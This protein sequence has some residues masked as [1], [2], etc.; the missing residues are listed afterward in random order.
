MKLRTFVVAVMLL[1]GI[2]LQGQG[3]FRGWTMVPL[4][5]LPGATFS[6]AFG[7]NDRGDA[8][9][10]SGTTSY[11]AHAVL[12]RDGAAIDLGTLGGPMS[13]ALGINNHGQ[14]VGE[15]EVAPGDSHAFLWDDGVMQDLAAA[16]PFNAARAINDR[17][18]VVGHYQLVHPL[19][20][21]DG[22]LTE[23]AGMISAFDVNDR[24][25]IAGSL[26]VDDGTGAFHPAIWRDGAII[27]LGLAEGDFLGVAKAINRRGVVVGNRDGHAFRWEN[28]TTIALPALIPGLFAFAEDVDDSGLLVAGSS[29]SDQNAARG[30]PHA[31]VWLS[32]RPIDLGTLPGD[33]ISTAWAVSDKGRFVAGASIEAA[34]LI[35]R[36]VLWT[37]R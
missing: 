29:M 11:T 22:V 16:G 5:H 30:A 2:V 14:I 10:W 32:G 3:R 25:E 15:A 12:W 33:T 4:P 9:G 20:W 24:L 6:E 34:T 31:V 8:V 13:R 1:C 27:D 35:N 17:G 36:A 19:L 21:R 18:D 7:V 37:S 28:G 26:V 23:L